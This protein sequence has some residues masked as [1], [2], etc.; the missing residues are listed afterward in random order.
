MRIV[1]IW[2]KFNGHDEKGKSSTMMPMKS[3][4]GIL[5]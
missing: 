5:Q 2:A 3:H 4:I 1:G